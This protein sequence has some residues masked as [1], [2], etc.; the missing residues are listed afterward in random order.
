[1]KNIQT[2]KPDLVIEKLKIWIHG[3][4][5]PDASDYWDANWLN[6][7][8]RYDSAA[9]FVETSGHIIHLSEIATFLEGS[10]KALQG[11]V[12]IIE[13]P[14]IEP[15]IGL[16]LERDNLGHI[17]GMLE[18]TPDHMSEKHEYALDMDQSYLPGVISQCK[19]ILTEYPIKGEKPKK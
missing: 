3:R 16:K 17:K 7:T 18:I 14:T 11:L 15:N 5:F 8:A 1:M 10:E 12:Q 2:D 19:M 9:S 13:L 4:Q 6:V